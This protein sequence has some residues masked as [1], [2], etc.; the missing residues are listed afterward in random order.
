MAARLRLAR[1]KGQICSFRPPFG[2]SKNYK[3]LMVCGYHSTGPKECKWR[4][5][6]PNPLPPH[7]QT[8]PF[9]TL[10]FLILSPPA[11]THSSSTTHLS[12]VFLISLSTDR[13]CNPDAKCQIRAVQLH[14]I[15]IVSLLVEICG[16]AFVYNPPNDESA[17]LREHV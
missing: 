12:S 6:F 2:F 16:P 15:L 5:D 9:T 1:E 8:Q 13:L 11:H 17:H 3:P 10:Y 4:K 7:H 14:T